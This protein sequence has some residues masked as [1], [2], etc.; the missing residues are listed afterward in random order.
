MEN[1]KYSGDCSVFGKIDWPWLV[2][3]WQQSP[4]FLQPLL[5]TPNRV[6]E[7]QSFGY[8]QGCR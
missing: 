3:I 7:I 5:S 1:G 8:V 2:Q 6:L 4:Q